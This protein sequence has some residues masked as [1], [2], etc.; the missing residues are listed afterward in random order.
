MEIITREPMK[1]ELDVSEDQARQLRAAEREIEEDLQ[2][3][4]AELR[5][6]AQRRLLANLKADQRKRVEE[7]FWR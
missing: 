5:A 4:I 3:Q 1:S 2:R 7:I 6:K